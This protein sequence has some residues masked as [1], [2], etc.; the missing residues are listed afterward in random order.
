M[1]TIN[2]SFRETIMSLHTKG[3]SLSRKKALVV[4][5]SIKGTSPRMNLGGIPRD[6]GDLSLQIKLILCYQ[7]VTL[8][9]F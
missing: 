5:I 4:L 7:R 1:I 8:L 9:L 2:Q 6:H 3:L